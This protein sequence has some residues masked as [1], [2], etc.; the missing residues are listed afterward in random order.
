LADHEQSYLSQ[1]LSNNPSA[2]G[3]N[4]NLMGKLS[5]IKAKWPTIWLLGARSVLSGGGH[6]DNKLRLAGSMEY[7]LA[8]GILS[9]LGFRKLAFKAYFDHSENEVL[10]ES[11]IGQDHWLNLGSTPGIAENM[12]FELKAAPTQT[13][14]AYVR[15]ERKTMKPTSPTAT[16]AANN[17]ISMEAWDLVMGAAS[18]ILPG[19]VPTFNGKMSYAKGLNESHNEVQ[20]AN[21]LLSGQIEFFPGRWFESLGATMFAVGYGFTNAEESVDNINQPFSRKHQLEGRV[22]IGKYDDIFRLESR[23]KWWQMLEIE[24]EDD[25]EQY[26][27]TERYLELIN[28][29]TYRPIY[30]SPIT[31]R[32]DVGELTRIDPIQELPGTSLRLLPALEWERR[33]SH[34]FVTKI[35]LEVPL[36]YYDEFYDENMGTID[37]DQWAIKPW[38]EVRL[39][40]RDFW[41]SSLLRIALRG[42]FQ[43]TDWFEPLLG[44]E[45]SYELTSSLWLDWEKAGSFIVRLGTIYVR[46]KCQEK[47]NMACASFQTI[48]P[49]IKAIVRF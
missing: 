43:W 11:T 26:N 4:Q 6:Q 10:G 16:A 1:K 44:A 2:I 5:F 18:R 12:R 42:S 22:A 21:A 40:L 38:A 23:G 37:F 29:L 35:R 9:G 8:K 20:T 48:Q 28:R 14:D 7:D 13:E 46:H 17:Q 3:I 24:F 41:R 30:T 15:F 36:Q 32:F 49:S 33:W 19:V 27:E 39:R 25:T 45:R 34:D 47:V 31:L